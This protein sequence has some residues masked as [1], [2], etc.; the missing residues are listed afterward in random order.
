M[1]TLAIITEEFDYI[2]QNTFIF[3]QQID[4]K[5]M[6]QL[7]RILLEK[8]KS[9]GIPSSPGK[10]KTANELRQEYISVYQSQL[11]Q[12]TCKCISKTDTRYNLLAYQSMTD[13]EILL[14]EERYREYSLQETQRV[15]Q[16]LRDFEKN[17]RK[18][19]IIATTRVA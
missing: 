8:I 18:T 3:K 17:S 16:D 19:K 7:Q 12:C 4:S 15:I 1:N 13:N 11:N 2:Q 10:I 14:S 6:T 5:N 9:M